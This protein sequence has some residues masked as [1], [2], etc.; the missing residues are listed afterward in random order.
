MLVLSVFNLKVDHYIWCYDLHYDVIWR[1]VL[2]HL[3][4]ALKDVAVKGL[5]FKPFMNVDTANQNVQRRR[6]F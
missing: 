1:M 6:H 2:T 4:D 3:N 5:K